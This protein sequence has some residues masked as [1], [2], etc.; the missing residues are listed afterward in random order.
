MANPRLPANTAWQCNAYWRM[1]NTPGRAVNCTLL[2]SRAIAELSPLATLLR[3]A[4]SNDNP[5]AH[6]PFV[7]SRPELGKTQVDVQVCFTPRR[8]INGHD[9][10][11]ALATALKAS[12]GSATGGWSAVDIANHADTDSQWWYLTSTF[13]SGTTNNITGAWA[14]F[15]RYT[16]GSSMES[17]TGLMDS[18]VL[19]KIT[20]SSD[21]TTV[22]TSQS[23]PIGRAA[24]SVAETARDIAASAERSLSLP[25]YVT[26]GIAVVA[27]TALAIGIGYAVRSV[28]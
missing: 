20:S 7:F 11:L 26:A 24:S 4:V 23:G 3:V 17:A 13:F 8:D 10:N 9:I 14:A 25:W 27:A 16:P 6:N 15:N 5:N 2:Q 19:G 21:S 12:G 1:G 18:L 22:G 28:R